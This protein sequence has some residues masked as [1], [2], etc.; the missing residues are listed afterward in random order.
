MLKP[1]IAVA[2]LLGTVTPAP[3]QNGPVVT[4]EGV[5]Q[6]DKNVTAPLMICKAYGGKFSDCVLAQGVT[7]N[8]VAFWQGYSDNEMVKIIN[9]QRAQ[10]ASL[11]RQL[12]LIKSCKEGAAK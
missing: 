6:D 1:L 2:L 8:D 5:K 12:R 9:Q 4:I 3:S 10:I 7:L 11:K